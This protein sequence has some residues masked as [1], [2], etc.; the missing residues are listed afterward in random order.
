MMFSNTTPKFNARDSVFIFTF[1]VVAKGED[2]CPKNR[3]EN[4]DD[5]FKSELP[6]FSPTKLCLVDP[7]DCTICTGSTLSNGNFQQHVL[8]TESKTRLEAHADGT[9]RRWL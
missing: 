7:E 1:T 9:I 3:P 2:T 8:L 4:F 5:L 6:G